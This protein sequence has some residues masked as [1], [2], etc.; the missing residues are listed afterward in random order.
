MLKVSSIFFL[1]L[2]FLGFTL[3][4]NAEPGGSLEQDPSHVVLVK[5]VDCGSVR[6][7]NCGWLTGYLG[8]TL[9]AYVSYGELAEFESKL[10]TTSVVTSAKL[11]LVAIQNDADQ[12]H[13]LQVRLSEK[14]TT[15]PVV[16]GAYGGGT[17]LRVFGVYDTHSF[18]KLWTL[19]GETRIYGDA[20]PSYVIW[21]SA[22]RWGTGKHVLSL[23]YWRMYRQRTIYD[24]SF[25]PL[26]QVQSDRRIGR[27]LFMHP[28]LR[29]ALRTTDDKVW[30]LGLDIKV[31]TEA[32]TTYQA[33]PDQMSSAPDDLILPNQITKEISLQPRIVYDDTRVDNVTYDGIRFVAQGGPLLTDRDTRHRFEIDLYQY[34]RI[35]YRLNLAT[36]VFVGGS[37]SPTLP[38]QFFLGGFDTVRGLP[39]GAM[40]GVRAG[41]ANFELRHLS[42]Q[43]RYLWLQSLIFLDVGSAGETWANVRKGVNMSSGVGIRLAIPQV[44]RLMFRIDYA[45]SLNQEGVH[46][47]TAGLNHFFDPYRPL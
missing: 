35:S 36:R 39:D 11:S 43:W 23:E 42:R 34:K 12:G 26:G 10:L 46:G 33:D 16:R 14:W 40:Y 5:E 20:P 28:I 17:P 18:G 38:N 29:G 21:A 37:T 22:P 27:F 3:E 9:P 24:Q 47:I 2:W 8:L 31:R 15:I 7:T 25:Q 44:Y 32:A 4:A 41:F 30:Q 19:G 13:I 45:W 6:R 1:L